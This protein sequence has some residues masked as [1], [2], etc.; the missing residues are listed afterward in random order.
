[1]GHQ[2]GRGNRVS[3]RRNSCVGGKRRVRAA[4]SSMASGRPSSRRQMAATAAV[5]SASRS[6][7]GRT[8]CALATSRRT[9]SIA[10]RSM[11]WAPAP[12]TGGRSSGGTGIFALAA[13]ASGERLVARTVSRWQARI[14]LAMVYA[15]STC[16]RLS[17]TSSASAW[18]DA[19]SEGVQG[20]WST[21]SRTPRAC[22]VMVGT[23]ALSLIAARG[24]NQTPSAKRSVN[25]AAISRARR[26]F[27]MPPGPRRVRTRVWGSSREVR[28]RSIS[29]SR[30][31]NEVGCG[32]KL[33]RCCASPGVVRLLRQSRGNDLKDV[34]R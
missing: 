8:S 9:A 31:T 20:L 30:P 22:C 16:S 26:V 33:C 10:V 13:T 34:L 28:P 21:D 4:A 25:R 3:N 2:P 29:S 27:P 5:L 11:S 24:T 23:S 19:R 17:S 32:G 12:V 15:A 7:P 6:S 1:M 14:K 18:R